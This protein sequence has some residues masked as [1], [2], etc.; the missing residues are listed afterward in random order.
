MP[1][2]TP[3]SM[4]AGHPTPN[5]TQTPPMGVS[6]ASGPTPNKGYEAAAMQRV[7]VVLNQLSELLPMA[8]ATSDVGKAVLSA[9]QA[10]SKVVPPGSV[11]PQAQKNTIDQL[12]QK[13]MQQQQMAKQMM[14]AGGPPGAGGGAPPQGAQPPMAA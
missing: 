2:M 10:L 7:G 14:G 3:P 6:S 4:G 12:Q 9:I 13:N 5:K 11:S 8:G 1:E